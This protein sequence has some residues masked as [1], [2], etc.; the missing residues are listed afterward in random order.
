MGWIMDITIFEL[1]HG[2]LWNPGSGSC[3]YRN[4]NVIWAQAFTLLFAILNTI[5]LSARHLSQQ[6]DE[7]VCCGGRQGCFGIIVC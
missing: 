1:V 4:A 7:F 5:I 2:S 3:L 6:I